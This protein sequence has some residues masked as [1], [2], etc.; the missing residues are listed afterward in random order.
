MSEL[1]YS[2]GDRVGD[3]QSMPYFARFSIAAPTRE[4]ADS[5]SLQLIAAM[6]AKDK[7]GDELVYQN[8]IASA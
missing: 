7:N 5:L 2:E 6:S 1:F 3:P 8:R 4:E